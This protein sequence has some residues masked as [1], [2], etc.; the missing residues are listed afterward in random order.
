MKKLTSRVF[1]IC[2][3]ALLNHTIWTQSNSNGSQ[4]ERTSEKMSAQSKNIQLQSEKIQQKSQETSENL[5]A[6][7]A[8]IKKII[9]I[10]EPISFFHSISKPASQSEESNIEAKSEDGN[11]TETQQEVATADGSLAQATTANETAYSTDGS[12]FWGNQNHKIYGCY[13]DIST[14]SILDEI[15]AA[16][17][18]AAVDV[19]FTA[20]DHFG[21]S[22][23]YAFLSPAL[24]KNDFFASYYFRGPLYKDQ[25]I[26]MKQ[27]D[28]VNESE[29]AMTNLTLAQFDKI[30]NNSQLQA[31]LKQ[32]SAFKDRIESRTKLNGKVI[33]VRTH[34][35][36]REAIGLIAI[37]DHLGTTG[38]SGCLKIKIKV[39]GFD[40]NGDGLADPVIYKN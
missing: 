28:E 32:T 20:T 11:R 8:N 15:D 17:N 18:T 35:Q 38:T 21:S 26:P 7:T 31:V 25:N 16:G 12:A 22:P 14:G 29:L 19:V 39:T 13:L 5:K 9:R 37:L 2:L 23:M 4:L 6:A 3:L 10:F 33:A 30:T 40:Q 34:I 1:I 27:W 36:N 24:V